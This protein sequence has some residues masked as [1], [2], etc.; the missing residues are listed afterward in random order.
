[1]LDERFEAA[2]RTMA[3]QN[4]ENSTKKR[5]TER[6]FKK[7]SLTQLNGYLPEYCRISCLYGTTAILSQLH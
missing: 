1:M 4:F 2:Q 6:F 3:Q 5:R 7:K